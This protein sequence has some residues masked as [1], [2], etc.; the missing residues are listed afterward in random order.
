MWS[1]AC[2][3]GECLR[4]KLVGDSGEEQERFEPAWSVEDFSWYRDG[5][6]YHCQMTAI[7]L[8]SPDSWV[9]KSMVLTGYGFGDR[10]LPPAGG[11]FSSLTDFFSKLSTKDEDK[12]KN[13]NGRSRLLIILA[14]RAVPGHHWIGPRLFRITLPNTR[15]SIFA[16]WALSEITGTWVVK[17]CNVL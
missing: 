8:Q 9:S 13:L 3:R 7:C 1:C 14:Q 2:W 4:R 15:E 6:C 11:R 16:P 12:G 5:C 10:N 17:Y